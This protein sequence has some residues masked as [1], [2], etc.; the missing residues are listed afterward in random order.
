MWLNPTGYI[1][2]RAIYSFP[3]IASSKV[4]PAGCLLKARELSLTG[5]SF[6]IEA[7]YGA[8]SESVEICVL[9]MHVSN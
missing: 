4:L 8:T 9:M 2:K 7:S 6:R 1:C 3:R 5:F